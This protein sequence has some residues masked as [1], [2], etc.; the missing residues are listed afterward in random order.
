MDVEFKIIL[1]DMRA[2]VK[3]T[4]VRAD[5]RESKLIWKSSRLLPGQ[6]GDLK[7]EIKVSSYKRIEDL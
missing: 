6:K 1:T 7:A 5:F 2:E 3:N 4:N